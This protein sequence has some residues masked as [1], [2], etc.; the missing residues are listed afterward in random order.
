M[1]KEVALP[2][3][4]QLMSYIYSKVQVRVN[5]N[6]KVTVGNKILPFNVAT[7]VEVKIIFFEKLFHFIKY[8]KNVI[9]SLDN[10][11]SSTLPCTKR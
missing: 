11:L 1:A 10:I 9:I 8:L 2:D 7:F 5:S 3:F 6:N 4:S